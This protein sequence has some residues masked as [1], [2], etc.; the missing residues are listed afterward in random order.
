MAD[1][2]MAAEVVQVTLVKNL[3]GKAHRLVHP[4]RCAV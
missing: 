4:Y 2:Y 3:G 1:G